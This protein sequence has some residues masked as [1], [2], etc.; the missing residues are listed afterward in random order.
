[1]SNRH[2]CRAATWQASSRVKHGSRKKSLL[3]GGRRQPRVTRHRVIRVGKGTGFGFPES[4]HE[5]VDTP[6]SLS[7]VYPCASPYSHTSPDTQGKPF[8]IQLRGWLSRHPELQQQL[9]HDPVSLPGFGRGPSQARVFLPLC[10]LL[11][12]IVSGHYA[13]HSM[14]QRPRLRARVILRKLTNSSSSIARPPSF[15]PTSLLFTTRLSRTRTRFS[16]SFPSTSTPFPAN[17]A[18]TSLTHVTIRR[19]VT[20]PSLPPLLPWHPPFRSLPP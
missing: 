20:F 7:A 5:L 4:G 10:F 11:L 12:I 17:S 3:R 8:L 6:T 2:L 19:R 16:L 1:M 18:R 15:L 13:T 9:P 14:S